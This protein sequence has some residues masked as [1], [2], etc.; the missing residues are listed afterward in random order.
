M[1]TLPA[2]RLTEADSHVALSV[3][4][5][6]MKSFH[7][8]ELFASNPHRLSELNMRLPGLY[9]DFSKNKIDKAVL[10]ALIKLA[11]EAG[12]EEAIKAMFDG[13][14]INET[15]GRAVMHFALRGDAPHE[16]S[17]QKVAED[18]ARVQAEM[19][20]FVDDIH[21]GDRLG[22]TGKK[23]TTVVNIGIGGSDLG[24][25]MVADA[26]RSFHQ[27]I[28]PYFVS[29]VDGADLESVIGEIELESTLFVVVSKTFTTQETLANAEAAKEI[30]VR[31]FGSEEAVAKHFAAVS[32][33]LPA[34]EAFGIPADQTFGF[35]D[36][37]GG[38]Y[39]LWGAVGLSV[40]V[41]IGW[42]H[43]EELLD[44]A[45]EMDRHFR[46]APLSDNLPVR[47]ALIGIWYRNYL[48]AAS[49]A[50]I[51][52]SHDL[53]RF[54]AYLQQA[55]MESNGKTVGRD[56]R[57]IDW[58][59][60]PVI[61]GEPGTNGQHAFFQLLHQ[62]SD[63]IPVDFI[64]FI[65]PTSKF[66]AHHQKL[67]ANC[68]A[69]SEALMNG[70]T[71]EEVKAQLSK[72]GMPDEEAKFLIPFKTFSGDRPSTTFLFDELNPRALGMLIALYEHKIFVQ[73]ILWNLY[74]F[75][76]WGVELGKELAKR[77]LPAIE[78]E[79]TPALDPS[80]QALLDEIRQVF[81][82]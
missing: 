14:A 24:P 47:M 50:V 62:G 26:L 54:P 44:G 19:K 72:Q 49:M 15:E 13:D 22:F 25:A 74:S 17:G 35:W 48:G 41:T 80:S 11:E 29:N 23:L 6:R 36:W 81:G 8:K 58:H 79:D 76:Q 31:H 59:S 56:G 51:P 4:A 66:K 68:L 3:H 60:G 28:S 10:G 82:R 55:D 37:V 7:L 39:S 63:L 53:R 1:P 78:D 73:G 67:L 30:L 64:A 46:S 75:D 57:S 20:A 40:A 69:Q 42:K 52:Y 61:W 71:G 16:L 12:L 38:R 27:G 33:N 2:F 5:E 43:F 65:R 9:A 18:V 70:K 77:I 21:S 32:T 34:V 45:A